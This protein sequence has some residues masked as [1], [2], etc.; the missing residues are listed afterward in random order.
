MITE[1]GF[2]FTFR[3]Y[4][5]Q[6]YRINAKKL[7]PCRGDPWK[8]SSQLKKM[9]TLRKCSQGGNTIDP[10]LQ[11][12]KIPDAYTPSIQQRELKSSHPFVPVALELLKDL[13]K[14]NTTAA[15]WADHKWN[16]EW[17]KYFSPPHIYFFRWPLITGND[18]T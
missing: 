6:F 4:Y 16:R 18:T 9:S 11:K 2:A 5:F 10:R 7:V 13:D 3:Y 8:L 1:L 12:R 17:K 14:Y 15:L